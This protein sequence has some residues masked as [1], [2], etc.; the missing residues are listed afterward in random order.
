MAY[1]YMM[2]LEIDGAKDQESSQTKTKCEKEM[3]QRASIIGFPAKFIWKVSGN[4]SEDAA[5]CGG[6]C[7][8]NCSSEKQRTAFLA[9][10]LPLLRCTPA[11]SQVAL[12]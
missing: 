6:E 3:E 2:S 10:L 1:M 9:Q 5:N 12:L 11:C 8:I 4:L 7:K